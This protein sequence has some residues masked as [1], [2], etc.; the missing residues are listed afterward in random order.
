MKHETREEPFAPSR[1]LNPKL[2]EGKVAFVTGGGSGIGE[3]AARML[4][5]HGCAVAVADK[6][7][8][9]AQTVAASIERSCG[10]ALAVG[11]DVSDDAQVVAA[12]ARVVAWRDQHRSADQTEP[13]SRRSEIHAWTAASDHVAA[14]GPALTERGKPPFCICS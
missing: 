2:F 8:E 9:L 3:A 6:R 1:W 5:Q 14:R 7:L 12:I 10:S 13:P 11:V 4:A